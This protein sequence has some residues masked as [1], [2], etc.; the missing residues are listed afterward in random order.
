MRTRHLFLAIGLAAVWGFL[1]QRYDA[2]VVAPYALLVPIFG[3]SSA[4]LVTG[5]P[6]SP[7]QL[8]AGA[9]ISGVL[10]A[11][12]RPRRA[13]RAV[14]ASPRTPTMKQGRTNRGR[15]R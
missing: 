14:Q 2:S 10:Y 4:A 5:E 13:I 7:A 11:G 1:L 12:T 15:Q 3:M 8:A 9:L 6:I